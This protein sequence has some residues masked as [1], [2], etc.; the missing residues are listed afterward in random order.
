MSNL[1]WYQIIIELSKKVGGPRNLLTI[2]GGTGAAVGVVGTKTWDWI[3]KQMKD[4]EGQPIYEVL[5]TFEV[6]EKEF[7]IGR[8]FRVLDIPGD[9]QYI[10]FVDGKDTEIIAVSRSILRNSTTW[11]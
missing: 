9:L 10:A 4:S 3:R 5:E 1:G 6:D 8:S 11:S 7:E 2:V